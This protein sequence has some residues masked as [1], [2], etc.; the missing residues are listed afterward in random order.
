[1]S[2][3]RLFMAPGMQHC[4]G[5]PGPNNFGQAGR[6]SDPQ[7]DVHEALEQWVEKGTA[8]EKLIAT[9]YIDDD[10]ARGVQMT[11]PLC[12]FPQR[13][14][15]KGKGDVNDAANFICAP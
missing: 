14:R 2:S 13:A 10:R 7:H 3:L 9:K 1:E 5:G 15:Y 4:G 6:P 12:P 11:R 8:P